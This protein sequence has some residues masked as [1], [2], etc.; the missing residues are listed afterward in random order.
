MLIAD[1][2]KFGFVYLTFWLDR[3]FP[4]GDSWGLLST[5]FLGAG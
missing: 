5:T 3:R 1:G 4:L 2:V